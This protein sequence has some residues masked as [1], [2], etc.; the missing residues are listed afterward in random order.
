[1]ERNALFPG[2]FDPVTLG[3]YDIVLR[4]SALF[5]KVYVAIGSNSQKPRFF[6]L[7][8]SLKMLDATFAGFPNIEIVHYDML[9]V[10][11][12]RKLGVKY[13]VRGIRNVSDFEFERSLAYANNKLYVDLETIFLDSKAEYVPISSTIIR[14]L[15]RNKADISA[16]VPEEVLEFL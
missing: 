6:P 4:A 1:M 13:I 10:D 9:T 14:E 15:V 12:C 3:H 16:F 7:D 5:D 11:F 2:S 8:K